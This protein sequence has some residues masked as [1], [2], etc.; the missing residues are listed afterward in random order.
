MLIRYNDVIEPL[1]VDKFDILNHYYFSISI[2]D[3]YIYLDKFY[4]LGN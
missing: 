2:Q 4:K 1:V 3:S